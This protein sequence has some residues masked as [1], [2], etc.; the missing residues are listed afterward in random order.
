MIA[1]PTSITEL[2]RDPRR[3]MARV[4]KEKVV[5]ILVHSKFQATLVDIEEW[6]RMQQ[7]LKDLRHEQFVKE[8]IEAE[9]EVE[10][11]EGHGPFDNVTDLMKHLNRKR[12]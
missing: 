1:Q 7:E 5:P 12:S 10:R 3:V 8:V 6:Q 4:K 11:G 9:N 2:R